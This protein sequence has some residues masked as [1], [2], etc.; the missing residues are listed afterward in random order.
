MILESSTVALWTDGRH[1]DQMLGSE[2]SQS[3][4]KDQA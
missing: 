4:L 1:E 2:V 3:G